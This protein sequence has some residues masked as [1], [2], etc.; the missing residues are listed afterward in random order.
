MNA[1]EVAGV[2]KT[3]RIPHERR[4]TLLE[5][6]LAAFRPVPVELLAA[7]Q[8]VTLAVPRGSTFGIIGANGSGKST[9]LK[10]MAG[11]LVPDTGRVQVTGTLAPL[12][13][14]G[15]GFQHEL[16]VRENVELYGAVLGYPPAEL[17]ARTE[18][19][20]AFA[21]LERFRDA[22][23]KN[24]SSGMAARLAFATALRADADTLLL[25]E[26]LAV[27]DA[28]FQRKCF[29]VFE[30][31]RRA[32]RTLVL[33]S[34]DLSTIQRFCERVCWLDRGR[35]AHLGP[36]PE[37][38]SLYLAFMQGRSEVTVPQAGETPRLGDG[39]IRYTGGALEQEDGTPAKRVR[40][41]TRLVLR[42]AI[43]AH[44]AVDDPNFGFVVWAGG[45]MVCSTTSALTGLPPRRFAPGERAELRIPFTAALANGAY[46]VSV[47]AGSRTGDVVYDWITTFATFIVEGS[48]TL[49]GVADLAPAFAW[50]GPA[51][52][53]VPASAHGAGA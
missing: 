45:Q 46:M 34:H 42:L 30:E 40:A 37:V 41:G 21:E 38:V 27:G 35:V 43:E 16:T 19:A 17:A 3:Y 48:T 23:L 18:A 12:L 39:R 10:V 7:L 26:V 20:I 2:S 6:V 53:A 28:H 15:L 49:E 47:A 24:L 51:A 9:L 33:V 31:L 5:G 4:T 36:A 13:E 22:K 1:I 25:D 52:A 44:D 8:D 50:A 11:L 32:G 14:L 29:A